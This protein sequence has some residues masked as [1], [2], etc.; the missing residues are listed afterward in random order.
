MYLF[1]K[2]ALSELLSRNKK[3]RDFGKEIIPDAIR[4]GMKVRHD[5]TAS[6]PVYL[7]GCCEI[8]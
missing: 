1:R 5:I 2:G 7:Q 6:T 3:A 8:T 4:S